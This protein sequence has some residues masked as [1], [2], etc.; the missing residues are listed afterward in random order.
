MIKKNPFVL[1][2]TFVLLMLVVSQACN[3]PGLDYQDSPF[4]TDDPEILT[5]A[6]DGAGADAQSSE[7]TPTPFKVASVGNIYPPAF[8]K[9]PAIEAKVP[10]TYAGG[11]TLP[12]DLA[13]VEMT[14]YITLSDAQRALLSQNGFVVES[15]NS[16]MQFNEFYQVYENIRYWEGQPAFITT[17][18]VFHVYHLLFDKMLRDLETG[19]FIPALE[20]LTSALLAESS[21]QLNTLAG[22]DLE[23]AAVRNAAYFGVAARLLGLNDPIPAAAESMAQAELALIEATASPNESPIWFDETLPDDDK[24]IED[25]SQYIPRG[26]YTRSE[27]LERYF[28]AMMWYGRM[29]LRLDNDMETRRALLVTQA[30]RTVSGSSGSSAESLWQSIY[31]PTTFIIGKSDDLSFYEY[32]G[33]ADAVYGETPAL[34]DYASDDLL[35]QFRL[36]AETLPPPQVNSMWVWI[37]QDVETVTKGFRVM[38]QRFTLD[39]YVF[40]QVMWRKVGTIDDPRDLPVALDFF[41]ALGSE[42]ARTILMDMG[43]DQ[44]ENYTTQLDKVTNEVSTLEQDSWTQNLYWT[45]LYSFDPVIEPKNQSYPPF[46]QNQ[47]WTRKELNTALSSWTELKH[48]T[49]LYAKQVM[50]EMGGGGMDDPPH[51]WVEPNPMVYARLLGLTRMTMEGLQSRNLTPE[52]TF[53][54]FQQLEELLVFCQYAAEAELAGQLLTEDDYWTIQFYGGQL[55]SL[56]IAAADLEGEGYSPILEDQKSALVADI[57]TGIGRV[58][59]EA[60]GYPVRIYVVLPDEPYRVAVGAVFSYYEFEVEPGGRLT[61]EAWQAQL[62]SGQ[63]PPQPDW[64][65]SF[66]AP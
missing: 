46:M 58:R 11:Y 39:Q 33:I 32:G 17:D 27:A 25:Y 23:D 8:G 34:Q 6:A 12:V 36:T 24:L 4:P 37:W 7:S 57:A 42:E 29:T 13:Q 51:G 26:H 5:L 63:A 2:I 30:L 35:A 1:V 52:V 9:Y 49:I 16:E 15:P 43:E 47:A 54:A 40:G 53:G 45:W 14:G 61:D 31:D 60:T 59:E 10:Q 19:Y 48:D 56:T 41:A 38:G 44:Y 20:E 28:R 55:E 18:S 65:S 50:A 3:F 21:S 22:S 66:S 62:E 64:T